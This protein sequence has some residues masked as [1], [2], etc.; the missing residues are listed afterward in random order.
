MICTWAP[1]CIL[2]HLLT[3]Y[4]FEKT[5]VY[6]SLTCENVNKTRHE[7]VSGASWRSWVEW[8]IVWHLSLAV[9]IAALLTESSRLSN[10]TPLISMG[11]ECFCYPGSRSGNMELLTQ[12]THALD[13]NVEIVPHG[14]WTKEVIRL[15]LV[16]VYSSAWWQLPLLFKTRL[17]DLRIYSI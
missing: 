2:W 15:V 7:A 14:R 6:L 4:R 12:L 11:L 13:K 5:V 9:G 3:I 1:V 10:I 8:R 16:Q 17:R